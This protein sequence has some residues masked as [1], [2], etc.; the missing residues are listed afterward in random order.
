MTIFLVWGIKGEG[1]MKTTSEKVSQKYVQLKGRDWTDMVKLYPSQLLRN[2]NSPWPCVHVMFSR[3]RMGLAL[4][5]RSCPGENDKGCVFNL[6]SERCA[7]LPVTYSLF[8]WDWN[9]ERA[10]T[11]WNRES[12]FTVNN[13]AGFPSKRK[14]TEDKKETLSLEQR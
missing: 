13:R 2:P 6:A 14:G 9:P 12:E 8:R 5:T 10:S 1:K 7:Y 11:A 4:L 3:N